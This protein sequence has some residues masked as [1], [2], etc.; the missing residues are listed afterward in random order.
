MA[1]LNDCKYGA[2]ADGQFM[3][4]SLLRA[5][6]APDAEQDQGK[7]SLIPI[8]VTHSVLGKHEFSWAVLPH[9]THFM[10]SDVPIAAQFFNSP[11]H[12]EY[13]IAEGSR[14]YTELTVE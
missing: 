4:L 12:G 3:R 14:R 7:P 6:T 13:F 10:Q 1:F 11:L 5:A 9:A 2:S 8:A